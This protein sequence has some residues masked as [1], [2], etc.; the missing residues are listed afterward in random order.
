MK[1]WKVSHGTG[2]ISEK[3]NDE[4]FQRNCVCVHPS[5]PAKGRSYTSQGENFENVKAG[6]YFYLCY[7][8][9]RIRLFGKFT[10][11]RHS[12]SLKGKEDWLEQEYELLFEATRKGLYA[13]EKYWWTPNDNSTFI[14]VSDNAAFEKYIL[15]PFFGKHL[16]NIEPIEIM[17]SKK[18]IEAEIVSVKD[19]IEINN[20]AIPPYQR[21]YRWSTKNVRQLLEDILMSKNAGKK[22]YRIG[23]I[24]L[25]DNVGNGTLD[26]VDGQQRITTLYLLQNASR[27]ELKN[28]LKY[29][30]TDSFE[31]IKSNHNFIKSWLKEYCNGQ[32]DAYWDYVCESCE[33]VKIVVT[34]LS[35]A[36]QM[37]DSQNGRGKELEPYNLLKAYHIRAMEQDSREEKIQCDQ[38]WEATT[39]Y[40]PTPKNENDP[41]IDVLK[42]LFAEQLYRSR[43]WSKYNEANEFS[44]KEI[45][46]FKGFTIDK[47]H[48]AIFPYQN[49]QLLQYLTSKFY[50]NV[51]SGTVATQNRFELGDNEKIDPFV[52]IN[53][54]IVNGKSFF[55][56]I[57]TYVEMYKQMFIHIDSYQLSEFKEFYYSYCL[58]YGSD[59]E[60]RKDEHS[61]YPKYPASRTGD[62]Y[63]RECYK[64][65][66]FVLF[67]KFG[68]KGL[69]KF[70]KTLYRLVYKERITKSQV[71]YRTVA[72]LPSKYF[73]IIVEAKD[74][75]DLAELDKK[76]SESLKGIS[77]NDKLGPEITD[78]I[79]NGIEKIENVENG[80][81]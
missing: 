21:P 7:S 14:Q 48:P 31:N 20:L 35:E 73:K 3:E 30:H 41:N 51:L 69:N 63:L 52:N 79:V 27:G 8:N 46:E 26:L 71:K 9:T 28:D 1:I 61:Y 78:F 43:I 80:N 50:K 11:K 25:H 42:Q 68:E 23:S 24:I 47:N 17:E 70:Y 49:P 65:L 53:Q 66:L 18:N 72:Q 55:D 15:Q 16:S 36:F 2:F 39:Q 59:K 44:K 10:G 32:E 19:L 77:T 62:T 37:F 40:D 45:D 60:K 22:N 12:S 34:N 6:D 58:N 29:N 33:F 38:R 76:L 57:E 5:T 74:L 54:Q 64:S 56:F 13:G 75:A 67:D 81:N 4:L